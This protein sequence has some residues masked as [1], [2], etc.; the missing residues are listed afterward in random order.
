MDGLQRAKCRTQIRD[1]IDAIQ[2]QG[3]RLDRAELLSRVLSGEDLNAGIAG[4][5]P[6]RVIQIV[7][8]LLPGLSGEDYAQL[9]EPARAA[10]EAAGDYGLTK[11]KIVFLITRAIDISRCRA[12]AG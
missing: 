6:P 3:F 5:P 9:L 7:V 2:R 10:T 4:W 11:N 12:V 1:R 8:E